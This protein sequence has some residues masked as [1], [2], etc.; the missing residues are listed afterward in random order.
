MGDTLILK[1]ITPGPGHT[2][3]CVTGLVPNHSSLSLLVSSLGLITL[4]PHR[5]F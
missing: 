2:T 3:S 1:D 5:V 4:V